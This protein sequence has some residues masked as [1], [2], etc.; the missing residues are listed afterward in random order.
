M[1]ARL[2]RVWLRL[3]EEHDRESYS[4]TYR[5]N[6]LLGDVSPD[7]KKLLVKSGKNVDLKEAGLPEDLSNIR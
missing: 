1:H 7:I 5:M 6:N 4:I 2:Q 3:E